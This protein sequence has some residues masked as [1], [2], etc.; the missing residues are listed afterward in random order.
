[1]RK[2]LLNEEL[3]VDIVLYDVLGDVVCGGFAMP[4]RMVLA[5]QIYVVTSSD[6][7]AMYAANNICRGMKECA[8][9]GGNRLG[10]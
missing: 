5:K 9:K 2:N 8:K 3:G 7:M 1:M 4:L 10:D 6:Y